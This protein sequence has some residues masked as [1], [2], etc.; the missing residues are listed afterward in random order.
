MGREDE[1]GALR[2][3]SQKLGTKQGTK[4]QIE[5]PANRITEDRFALFFPLGRRERRQIR[6]DQRSA[7][8]ALDAQI[9][10]VVPERGSQGLVAQH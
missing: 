2:L 8:A 9:G 1:L 4:D 7:R 3:E 6:G 10:P 5:G